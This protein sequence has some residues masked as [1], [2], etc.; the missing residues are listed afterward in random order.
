MTTISDDFIESVAFK[1][2]NRPRKCLGW[3]TPYEVFYK[4][5]LHL[6]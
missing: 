3:K 2:N 5:V 1:I 4:K 6:I